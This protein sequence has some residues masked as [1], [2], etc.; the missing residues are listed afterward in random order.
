MLA[1]HRA[2]P[3]YLITELNISVQHTVKA[4]RRSRSIALLFP[5]HGTR[6]DGL[7]TPRS[8]RFTPV[9]ST[10]T[11]WKRLSGH[12]D[13]S[14]R[15]L[16]KRKTLY[17]IRDRNPKR[18]V[19]SELLHRPPLTKYITFFFSRGH[20]VVLSI[21]LKRNKIYTSSNTTILY[22]INLTL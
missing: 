22:F 14:G 19:C 5:N 17:P 2:T 18:P 3:L 13:E 4:Q 11:H 8:D 10:G 15:V 16:V 9:K 7:S 20:P 21:I 6:F 1:G 12:Q